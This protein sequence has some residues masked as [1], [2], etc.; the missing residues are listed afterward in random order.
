[1]SVII[2]PIGVGDLQV[3]RQ[4]LTGYEAGD[5]SHIENV[6][7]GE[8]LRRSTRREEVNEL[9]VTEETST[10]QIEERDQQSTSRN[11]LSTEAQKESGQQTVSVKDQT[12]STEYGKLV[13]NSKSNYA[14][15]VTSRAVNS[16]TQ[17]V[18]LQRI[19]RERRSFTEKA[20]H[21]LDNRK[22]G[23]TKVRGIYQWVDRKYKARVLNYGKRLL[24][25]V[26]V[27]E[28]AAFLIDSLK[29]AVQ[30]ESFQLTKPMN[31]Q[32]TPTDVTPGTYRYYATRYGVTGSV[33]P[34]PD[35][36]VETFAYPENKKVAAGASAY[37]SSYKIHIPSDYTAISGY[38]QS[39][40]DDHAGNPAVFN[41]FEVFV[42]EDHWYR[43]G[44]AP[45]ATVNTLNVSFVMSGET[46][47]VPVTF[48][49]LPPVVEFSYA[50]GIKCKR[51]D[52]AYEQWQLKTHAT[53]LQ[54]Y[55]RQL[56]DYEDKLARYQAAVRSQM[57]LA[58]NFARNPSIEQEELKKAF[59][60][61]LLAEHFAQ[62][63][64]PTPT[65]GAFPPNPTSVRN[66]GAMVAFFE[67][68]FEWE[69]M[70][71]TYYP[72]FWGRQA[73]WGELVLVQDT[74]PQFEAFLKAGAA[75]VVIPVRPGFEG[76][77]A[78]YQETGD[79]W[80]G[81]EIP[82][83]FSDYYVSIIDEI[84]ARNSAPGD[85]VLVSEWEFK[86]PTTLIML[87]EDEKLPEWTV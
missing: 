49:T 65:P 51:T 8:L 27:P 58:Q 46:G 15:S 19:Q 25:D 61:L 35:E 74:D 13:E 22:D 67:R 60:A 7:E 42:G 16:L 83:M 54:G 3:V 77:I 79:I 14:Q 24:Y 12:T 26:V 72:Y 33:T 78:H 82:D 62:A 6:L 64:V 10:T 56:A 29:R 80:M 38:I 32:I 57:A 66:W 36:F 63:Y 71:Y 84:K 85:E 11:E 2:R 9:T 53:I 70:M 86:L 41:V 45:N 23:A 39:I 37:F 73:K 30:P 50:I 81:E 20:V 28:P 31:P 76:V 21:E 18:R 75:R 4:Q 55:Q 68:A 5:V 17:M 43:F 47:D 69:N 59:I 87:K 1:M 44:S 40:S 48:R 52:K 34:P